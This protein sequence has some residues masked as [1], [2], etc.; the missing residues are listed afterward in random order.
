[1]DP[2][3][4]V[5]YQ[6]VAALKAVTEAALSSKRIAAR[7]ARIVGENP[8]AGVAT[9]LLSELTERVEAVGRVL[10]ACWIRS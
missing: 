2:E 5:A 8:V 7:L 9:V 6:L 3:F 4:E 1:L 10:S